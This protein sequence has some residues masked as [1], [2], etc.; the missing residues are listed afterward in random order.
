MQTTQVVRLIKGVRIEPLYRNE[1]VDCRRF[2]LGDRYRQLLRVYPEVI[3][4]MSRNGNAAAEVLES[5]EIN[6]YYNVSAAGSCVRLTLRDAAF[7]EQYPLSSD[8]FS[9]RIVVG[10][11]AT[12]VPLPLEMF[13]AL[14][15]LLPLLAGNH[16]DSD[17]SARLQQ[18]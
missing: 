12:I 14:G 6:Q 8:D 18:S 16:G 15:M 11:R 17:I 5:A 2:L 7:Q 9:L 13:R 10:S 3:R 4:R 1:V